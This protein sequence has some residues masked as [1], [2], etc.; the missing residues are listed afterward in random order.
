M[1]KRARLQKH[2]FENEAAVDLLGEE[3]YLGGSGD[4]TSSD[5][6]YEADFIDDRVYPLSTPERAAYET[7]FFPESNKFLKKLPKEYKTLH[8][9]LTQFDN[10]QHL[11]MDDAR[12]DKVVSKAVTNSLAGSK[13]RKAVETAAA[14]KKAN[15]AKKL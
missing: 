11:K 12:M 1:S 14:R 8:R 4:E 2:F 7:C 15:A 13:K 3:G 6:S 10:L 5:E 9:C